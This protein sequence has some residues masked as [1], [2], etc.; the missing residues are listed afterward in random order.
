MVVLND[1]VSFETVF[2]ITLIPSLISVEANEGLTVFSISGTVW[3]NN[4][5]TL[6]AHRAMRRAN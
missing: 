4:Y 3:E 5:I 2:P 6:F 1:L